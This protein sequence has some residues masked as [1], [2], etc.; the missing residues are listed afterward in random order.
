MWEGQVQHLFCLVG[1]LILVAVATAWVD[2]SGSMWG[3]STVAWL[4]LALIVPVIHQAF[5]MLVWRLELHADGVSRKLGRERGFRLYAALFAVLAIGR[6]LTVLGTSMANAGSLALV[7]GLAY[8]IAAIMLP[9]FV[10]LQYSVIRYFGFRRAVGADHFEQRYREMPL[11]REGIFRF[12][13]NAMY[14][15]GF[16]ILWIIAVA[17]RSEAALVA[18]AFNHAY[19]WGHYVFTEKPDMRHIYGT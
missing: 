16:L 3:I 5:V 19:I 2:L 14:A 8:A 10:Y 1:L 17:F 6:P 13:P 18:A 9:P 15:V 7:P 11:V 4:A 12:T